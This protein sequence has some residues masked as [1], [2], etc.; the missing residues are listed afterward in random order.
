M[1]TVISMKKCYLNVCISKAVQDRILKVTY[2]YE[3]KNLYIYSPPPPYLQY[4]YTIYII[5]KCI[6]RYVLYISFRIK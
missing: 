6:N 4:Q 2:L 3:L 1:L 5:S